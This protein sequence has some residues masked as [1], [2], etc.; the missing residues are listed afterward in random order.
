MLVRPRPAPQ[1]RKAT[2]VSSPG[3]PLAT[4]NHADG[5]LG[6]TRTR[7]CVPNTWSAT[8]P[9]SGGEIVKASILRA[10]L[11]VAIGTLSTLALVACFGS[12]SSSGGAGAGG[13]GGG[14][15][16]AGG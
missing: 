6:P 14:G 7:G 4:M 9:F 10:G 5:E 13:G 15:G 11:S 8:P 1:L 2:S 16:G 3:D 12:S